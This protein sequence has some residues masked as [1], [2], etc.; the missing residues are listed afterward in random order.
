MRLAE[1]T[2]CGLRGI[3]DQTF[4][5][6][7]FTT[8]IG[9]NNSGKSTVLRSLQLLLNQEKPTIEEWHVDHTEDPITIIGR[10][11]N[12]TEEERNIPGISSLVYNAEIRLRLTVS[13]GD[14]TP[15]LHYSAFIRD[16]H[17]EGWSDSW[18]SLSENIRGVAASLG[19]NG[20]GWRTKANQERIREYIRENNEDL[21]EYGEPDWTDAGISIKEALKQGLPRVEI[22][23]AVR[24]A[25]DEGQLTQKKNIFAEILEKSILPEIE[26]TDEYQTIIEKADGLSQRMSS[27]GADG[28][29]ETAKISEDITEAAGSVID[30]KVLF[31]LD[32]PDIKK[33]IGSGA[34]IRLS[35][36]T[37][38]PIHLQGH[39][40]QRTLIYA[41]VRYIARQRAVTQEHTRQT[42]LLF[43]EPEIYVHPQ[44][45]RILRQSLKDLS[46]LP[47]WQV[48]VT[49]HSPV[50]VDVAD[51]PQ[52]LIIMRR[53][54]ETRAIES[55]Q[56]DHDPFEIE[57]GV[58]S[59]RQ[60]LRATL[61]FHPTVC[62]AFFADCAV[63]VE[64]DSET[65]VLGFA[66]DALLA[67]NGESCDV[68]NTSIISCGGKWTIIPIARL[69]GEFGITCKVIHDRDRKGLSDDELETKP[70]FHPFKANSRILEVVGADNVYV[71]D[72]TLEDIMFSPGERPSDK[73]KPFTAWKRMREILE[74]QEL[75]GM[76]ELAN[77]FQFAFDTNDT[78]GQQN[79]SADAEDGAAE[80]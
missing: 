65:A 54:P 8:F 40:A 62:E 73:D 16:E 64:G 55:T 21:V 70:A 53:N 32:P 18:G 5:I 27:T 66:A 80:G 35:D 76:D 59:E 75:P 48:L 37:E 38:T 36:G 51:I 42:I 79:L 33:I 34:R 69:L 31:R 58:V 19:I 61:D 3:E 71:V 25:K 46:S 63:L 17:I 1:L 22:V 20:A 6:Y 23:P 2:V 41:L 74:S 14:K 43:E 57:N 26:S 47:D 44:L 49:T 13:K 72:D 60:M 50:I 15:E 30:L 39:G 24:D 4:T 52:S 45:L 77:L 10:F 11:T 68:E 7:D 12:I 28:L 56:L 29:V 67:L 9:P 78:A